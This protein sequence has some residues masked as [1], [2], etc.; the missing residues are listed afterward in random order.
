MGQILDG[1]ASGMDPLDLSYVLAALRLMDA[2]PET[3]TVIGV[4]PVCLDLSLE[5]SPAVAARL[6]DLIALIREEL[7]IAC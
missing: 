5:L 6:P 1:G 3:V 2:T 7:T 4:E